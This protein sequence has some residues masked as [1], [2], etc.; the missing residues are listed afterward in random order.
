MVDL[1]PP[2]NFEQVVLD[3]WRGGFSAGQPATPIGFWIAFMGFC[4]AG[5]C[6]LEFVSRFSRFVSRFSF[7]SV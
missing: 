6:G 2:F 3:P 5:A 7:S 1:I 4:V